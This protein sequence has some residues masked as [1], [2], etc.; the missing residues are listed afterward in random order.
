MITDFLIYLWR[1][2]EAV[3]TPISQGLIKMF[4]ILFIPK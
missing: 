3:M 2:F 1:I 4:E